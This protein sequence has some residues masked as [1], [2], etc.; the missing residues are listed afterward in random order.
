MKKWKKKRCH[1]VYQTICGHRERRNAARVIYLMDSNI[2]V[3]HRGCEDGLCLKRVQILRDLFPS[4]ESNKNWRLR[5]NHKTHQ[6]LD[7]GQQLLKHF[8]LKCLSKYDAQWD[9]LYAGN[10]KTFGLSVDWYF[11]IATDPRLSTPCHCNHTSLGSSLLDNIIPSI[12]C[13]VFQFPM[14]QTIW[15]C[16]QI[17]SIQAS[18]SSATAW[19]FSC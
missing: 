6:T 10:M 1:Q 19:L 17:G 16:H 7:T 8:G 9:V 14:K 12:C 3:W 11:A 4:E 15:L 5:S 2:K 13:F 18:F